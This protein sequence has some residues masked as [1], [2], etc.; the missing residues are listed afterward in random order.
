MIAPLLLLAAQASLE[1][2]D[3][4]YQVDYL[5][6]PDGEVLEVGGMDFLPD[7]R[8]A[9]STR[10][11]QVWIVHDPLA[12]DPAQV[13]F[14]LFAE[15]LWEGLGLSVVDGDIYVVQRGELS[16]LRDGDG[17]GRCDFIDT[18]SDDWGLSGNYHEF[19]YGLPVDDQG[20]FYVSLNVAFFSPKWWH[21][22][23]TVP[24]RGWVMKIAPDGTTSP[25]AYGFR[26]PCGLDRNRAGDL[27][28]T[29]NQGDWMA[30]SPVFHVREGGFY[31][32]PASLAWTP[33]YRASQTEPSD[34][35]PP[36]AAAQ[37]EPAAVWLPYKW[38]RSPGNLVE[39]DSGGAFGPFEGQM[40]LAELTNGM[41]VRLMLEKV[42][43]AYQGAA[44]PFRQRIGS[45]CRVRFAP[46]GTL[47]VGMTN[48]GWGG[49][50]PASGLARV[51][52]RGETPMEIEGVHLIDDGFEVTFTQPVAAGLEIGRDSVLMTQYDYDYWW[53][54]G[55]PVR[56]LEEL[57]LSAAE[58]SADRR[59]LT[60]RSP[61]LRPARM[62][63]IELFGVEAEGGVPLLHPEVH[64]TI[65]QLPEGAGP[66]TDKHLVRVVPPPPARESGEEGW[67][68]LTFGDAT[69]GWNA[70]GWELVDAELDPDQ[71]TRLMTQ[72]GVNALTNTGAESPSDYVSKQVFGDGRIHAEFML[73]EEGDS[74]VVLMGRYELRLTD[75][76]GER[77]LTP[78]HCGAVAPGPNSAGVAPRFHAYGGAGIWHKLDIEFQAPRFDDQGNKVEDAR[79]VWVKLDD[80]LL[81]ENVAL[82]EPTAGYAGPE[83]AEGPLVLRGTGSHAAFGNI[84]VFPRA[85]AEPSAEEGWTPL[86]T[87]EDEELPDWPTTGEAIW[88]LDDGVL[89]GEGPRGHLFT[90]RADY[91]DVEIRAK[92][93]IN[94]GG[95]SGLYF[96]ATPTGGWPQGYEAQ[97]N[98]S[99][100]D[101]QKTGSLYGLHEVRTSLVSSDTWFD[102][103]VTCRE[104]E[105]GTHV[106]IRVNGVVFT[107][108]V[109]TERRHA[110][111]HLALQQHHDGSVLE[112]KEM[113][114]RELP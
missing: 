20:N 1:L 30:V 32:H 61:G 80:T 54:Y 16:R 38:S 59:T 100:A 56:E 31:G 113:R 40:F 114:V 83:T 101:P 74:G 50:P 70:E 55:S 2:E 111:G 77:R 47:M 63:S 7:G 15:G 53:E 103:H 21:G 84:R 14:E 68:R 3:R 19:A 102:Y 91:T 85:Q 66:A 35:V 89:I 62:A 86:W 24:Y 92:V 18:I 75:S 51:R 52:W 5:T 88:T 90:P 49:F 44:I 28:A 112:V 4:Y 71:P 87:E 9:L 8:L 26:S 60:V 93:K 17:D 105:A 78:D 37:R 43:G 13:R 12:D 10:R 65:N 107:D 11:G 39:D 109:D 98:S 94:V 6:P 104:V 33:E 72:K 96:R 46:D 79:L 69:D 108:Y 58:L 29:D 82:P 41:V 45:A 95:N 25:F 73:P 22:K 110:S 76:E 97:I 42:R 27:F 36:A 64:Y 34:T 23:S 99:F 67:L 81:H 57:E 106:V 48:R